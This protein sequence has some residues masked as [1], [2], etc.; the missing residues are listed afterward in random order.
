MTRTPLIISIICVAIALFVFFGPKN[1]EQIIDPVNITDTQTATSTKSEHKNIAYTIEGERIV[2][3]DGVSEI[4]AAPGSVSKIITRYFGNELKKDLDGDGREDIAFFITQEKGGSGEFYYIVVARN[5]V[6]GAVGSDAVFLGDRI[7]PQSIDSGPGKSFIVNYVDRASGAPMTAEPTIGKS[8]RLILDA[9]TMHLG[10]VAQDFEGEANPNMMT[11]TM[12][13]WRWKE[14]QYS[15][16][17]T[18]TPKKDVFTLTFKNDST[19]GARTDCNGIGGNYRADTLSITLSD[20]ISTQMYCEGSQEQEFSQLLQDTRMYAF[21]SKG[22]LVL[23]LKDGKGR[24]Y[25]R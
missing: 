10:E 24:V 23:E 9:N 17:T 8:L 7:A 19:F 15:N 4:E 6:D 21:T 5:T 2:L 1:S 25:F 12:K 16:G 18:L 20:M 3:N 11:L 22:E 14:T 13:E